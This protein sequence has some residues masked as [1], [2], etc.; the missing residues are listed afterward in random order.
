MSPSPL[1]K[2]PRMWLVRPRGLLLGF[3][4]ALAGHGCSAPEEPHARVFEHQD[5]CVI[6]DKP[7]ANGKGLVLHLETLLPVLVM[8]SLSEHD[9]WFLT[10][11]SPFPLI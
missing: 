4:L 7:V 11:C 3:A 6:V 10:D 1:L 8:D 2:V 5:E 9:V